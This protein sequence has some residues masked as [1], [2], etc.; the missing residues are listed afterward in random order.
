MPLQAAALA[1]EQQE[2]E[3]VLELLELLGQAGLG[4]VHALGGEGDVEAGIGDGDEI[5]EL[6]QGHVGANRIGG[7]AGIT[8]AVRDFAADLTTHDRHI[9]RLIRIKGWNKPNPRL[10]AMSSVY[11]VPAYRQERG[12]ISA[13]S[14]RPLALHRTARPCCDRLHGQSTVSRCSP[15]C[16]AAPCWWSAAAAWPGA[17]WRRC[18]RPARAV[19]VGAPD[20]D[21]GAGA[22]GR[23]RPH[24]APGGTIR[25]GTGS[26]SAWLVIAATDDDAV[27]RAVAAAARGAADLGQR[28]RRRRASSSVQ[29]PA[30][31]ERGPLQIAISSGG[32]APMLARHLREQLEASA[33]RFPGSAGRPALARARTHPHPPARPHRGTPPILRPRAGRPGTGPA[34]PWRHLAA[35][36]RVQRRV[37]RGR[38]TRRAARV[39]L[40]GAGPGD[41]GLLT[42]RALRVL[43]EADVILHDR[44]VSN[45]VLHWPAAM[46]NASKSASRRRQPPRHAGAD[47]RADARTRPRRQACGAAEGR[48]SVRVRSRRR[49]TG[50]AARARHR[51][52][53]RTRHH[54]RARLRRLCR[55]PAHPSRPRAVGATWSPRTARTRLDTLDWASLAQERQTLAV[56]MGVAGLDAHARAPDRARPR[57]RPRRSRWSRT[58]RVPSSASSPG[59]WPNSP[60][61]PRS[62]A[63]QSHR[64]C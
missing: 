60:S 48:R 52:R 27:N 41:P 63:V 36:T 22:V 32:G 17:R 38:R 43:N 28:R 12:V 16:M 35:A 31:V 61:A 50:S 2:A 42:L 11:A 18:W 26:T 51:V 15:T 57:G 64:R 34:A 54:R 58:A 3:F 19:R 21:R 24:R 40:V 44:L 46:P 1:G 33:R 23:R 8:R 13:A 53:S 47:P 39:A 62:H 9:Y 25:A 7:D 4:R 56:Y 29:L 5:A 20:L 45:E 55:H 59:R 30:R 37:G 14:A 10:E 49:G 6:G